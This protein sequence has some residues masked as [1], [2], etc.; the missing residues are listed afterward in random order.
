MRP[1]ARSSQP[2]PGFFEWCAKPPSFQL[3]LSSARGYVQVYH[4]LGGHTPHLFN[5]TGYSPGSNYYTYLLLLF[6]PAR[7]EQAQYSTMYIIWFY[8]VFRGFGPRV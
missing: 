3:P 5:P 6:V 4:S 2:Q 1:R 8:A 7:A